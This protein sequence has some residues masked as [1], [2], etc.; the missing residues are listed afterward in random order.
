MHVDR[1]AAGIVLYDLQ[2][3]GD[4]VYLLLKCSRNGHWTPPK[5]HVDEG[6]IEALVT[7]LR[8]TQEESGLCKADLELEED[9]LHE[10]FYEVT[11]DGVKQ[12]KKVS[13]FLARVKFPNKVRLSD[14]HSEFDW[15]SLQKCKSIFNTAGHQTLTDVF[16]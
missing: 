15:F 16:K 13:Y 3:S 1:H 2:E 10:I 8:E 14:E 6:E 9:F 12:N 11:W 4:R 7:A 5:G